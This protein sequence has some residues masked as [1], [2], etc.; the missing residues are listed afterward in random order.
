MYIPSR[1]G[2]GTAYVFVTDAESFVRFLAV[3]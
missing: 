1:F 3:C 2:T